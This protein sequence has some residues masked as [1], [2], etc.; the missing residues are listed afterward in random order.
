MGN[1]LCCRGCWWVGAEWGRVM[2]LL[3]DVEAQ[4]I[5]ESLQ[6]VLYQPPIAT[7]LCQAHL[8]VPTPEHYLFLCWLLSE[9]LRKHSQTCWLPRGQS[10]TGMVNWPGF[11]L[12]SS[13]SPFLLL[14]SIL[15]W[16]IIII[17]M[18]ESYQALGTFQAISFTLSN[19]SM[20]EVALLL[21]FLQLRSWGS[22]KLTSPRS[23]G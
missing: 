16:M 8:Q 2:A 6:I 13:S 18:F 9:S 22:E 17:I 23:H 19:N 20:R 10:R 7:S 5:R 11:S 12:S 21:L 4:R 14:P 15:P 3:V 1:Q